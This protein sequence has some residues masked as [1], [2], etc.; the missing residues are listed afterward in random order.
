M[1]KYIEILCKQNPKIKLE[2]KNSE[3]KHVEEVNS[4]DVFK[5]M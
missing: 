5:D 1:D 3:C 2:C 4:K